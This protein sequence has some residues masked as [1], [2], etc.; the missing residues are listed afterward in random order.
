[1]TVAISLG[2]CV[3]V[4]LIQATLLPFIGIAISLVTV[5]P[6]HLVWRTLPSTDD[7]VLEA[8][9]AEHP[10]RVH[11]AAGLFRIGVLATVALEWGLTY[12][13]VRLIAPHFPSV[14][15]DWTYEIAGIVALT[16]LNK[17]RKLTNK[18]IA[19]SHRLRG[20][21]S[22]VRVSSGSDGG[23]TRELGPIIVTR[24]AF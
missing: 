2:L 9:A 20:G 18:T 3:L 7:D 17:A 11:L 1:M 6:S 22:T 5:Y 15:W 19:L 12:L 13:L 14:H 8:F 24:S 16:S 21:T 4:A 10:W 23:E